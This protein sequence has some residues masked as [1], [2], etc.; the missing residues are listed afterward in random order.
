MQRRKPSK[1]VDA[2]PVRYLLTLQLWMMAACIHP[3]RT[4]HYKINCTEQSGQCDLRKTRFPHRA[5]YASQYR[6]TNG[7]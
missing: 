6:E 3:V 4:V 2:H 5:L 1:Q 7:F